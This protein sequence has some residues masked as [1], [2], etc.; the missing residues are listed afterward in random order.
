M[1]AP[2]YRT[3][4]VVCRRQSVS[5]HGTR[6]PLEPRTEIARESGSEIGDP[7]GVGPRSGQISTGWSHSS[8]SC[9]AI[10]ISSVAR[11]GSGPDVRKGGHACAGARGTRRAPRSARRLS[12][13]G[14]RG[15][16]GAAPRGAARLRRRIRTAEGTRGRARLSRPAA[17]RAKS[18]FATTL[19]CDGTSRRGSRGFSWTSSRTPI[20]CR[21]SCCCCWPPTNRTRS[22]GSRVSPVPGKLFVVG[23]PKQSIYRFRRADVETYLQVCEQ[24]KAS[25]ARSRRAA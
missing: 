24:L 3:Q 16:G 8:S 6:P 19:P 23:D 25:G 18:A 4:A 11:K 10:A 17:P 20:R 22:T 2:T 5:R 15:S 13:R 7:D 9:A 1:P 12:A 21:P 14:R